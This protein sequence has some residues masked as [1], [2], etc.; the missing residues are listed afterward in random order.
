MTISAELLIAHVTAHANIEPVVADFA[1]RTVLAGL[2]ARMSR[3]DKGVLAGELPAPFPAVLDEAD[4]AL[5]IE[6]RMLAQADSAGHARELA[7][8]ACRALAETLSEEALA[9]V[10]AAL[11]PSLAALA[12]PP[13]PE[14]HVARGA[15]PRGLASGHFG[16]SHPLAEAHPDRTHANSVAAE[17][18]HGDAK[19]SSGKPTS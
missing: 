9:I 10:R 18:P 16:S 13:A 19:L 8:A 17:N 14:Y 2:G 12:E 11:P 5:P 15:R 1:L 7:A 6:E 3:T 4:V